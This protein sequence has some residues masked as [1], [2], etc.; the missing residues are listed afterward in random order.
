MG[1]LNDTPPR[2]PNIVHPLNDLGSPNS[3]GIKLFGESGI[4]SRNEDS[5]GEA[6]GSREARITLY[7][8]FHKKLLVS[9]EL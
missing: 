6:R 8:P 4:L 9:G 5:L 7:K 1:T 3:V 2:S